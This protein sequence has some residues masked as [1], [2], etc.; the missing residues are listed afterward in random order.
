[1]S[2][3]PAVARPPHQS[4]NVAQSD[5]NADP[6]ESL[7]DLAAARPAPPDP[8][9]IRTRCP[10]CGHDTLFIGSGGWL[11]CSWLDCKS[12]GAINHVADALFAAPPDPPEGWHPIA[13][14]PKDGTEVLLWMGGSS[15]PR[16]RVGLWINEGIYPST[17]RC[18]GHHFTAGLITHW[19]RLPDPPE[20]PRCVDC[21]CVLNAGEAKAFTCCDDCWRKAYPPEANK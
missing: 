20:G 14:C 4:V 3:P 18:D 21:G 7:S 13:S 19:R 11:V 10:S 6:L 2:D 15:L 17:W 9:R 8:P 12:P 5:G 1:M 16:V